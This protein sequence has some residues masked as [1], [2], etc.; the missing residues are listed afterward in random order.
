MFLLYCFNVCVLF[1]YKFLNYFN[2]PDLC[3]SCP[4][5]CLELVRPTLTLLTVLF[6]VQMFISA[7]LSV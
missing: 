6:N 3:L 1:C 2:F 7:H 5:I 4:S